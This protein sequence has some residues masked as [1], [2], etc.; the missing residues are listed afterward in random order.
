MGRIHSQQQDRNPIWNPI[1]WQVRE[2]QAA[3][4]KL[5]ELGYRVG[6]LVGHSKGGFNVFLY[7]ATVPDV[8]PRIVSVSGRF[9]M[10]DGV[11]GRF[12]PDILDQLLAQGGS[13]RRKEANGFEW[14]LT[15]QVRGLGFRFERLQILTSV[16]YI[17]RGPY[18]V[19]RV[20]Y[21]GTLWSDNQ[22]PFSAVHPANATWQD[23]KQRLDL[24]VPALARA[25]PAQSEL[26]LVHGTGDATIPWQ[27][28]A[29]LQGLAPRATTVWVEGADHNYTRHAA[30]L[31][32]EVLRAVLGAAAADSS[33]PA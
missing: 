9:K 25:W 12:G 22:T 31:E 17:R 3:V 21:K 4:R 19:K 15:Y 29:W 13:V 16:E 32:R 2:I 26:V 10:D 27:E 11:F 6:C 30:E 14:D 24:D 8:P 20:A 18:L 23:L 7:G 1:L 5:E 33:T 28:A